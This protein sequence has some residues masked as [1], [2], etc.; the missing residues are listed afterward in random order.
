MQT[1]TERVLDDFEGRWSIRR[2]ILPQAGA[3]GRFEGTAEW[4]RVRNGLDYAEKGL[5]CLSA[6]A[7]MRAERRYHWAADLSVYFEDGRFFHRVP[8][9]GGAT[10]HW[11]A[12]DLYTVTYDFTA[13]P[14][15]TVL[16]HVHGPRKAY[17]MRSCFTRL[18]GP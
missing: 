8:A 11:C 3:Q 17:R 4:R 12:P 15:F 10:Q 16:W 1:E 2:D 13:W 14:G 7:P 6:A 5:L 9:G 18:D